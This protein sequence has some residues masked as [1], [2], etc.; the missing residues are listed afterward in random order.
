[1]PMSDGSFDYIVVEA[2]SAGCVLADRLSEGNQN[3]VLL[4]E[5]GD[6]DDKRE[7]RIPASFPD[8]YRTETDWEYYTT[9]QSE[10]RDR[11]LYWP[12]GRTLGG[13]SSINAMIYVRGHP[14]DYNRWA[15]SGNGEWAYEDVLPYF[16]R[17][18][19]FLGSGGDPEYHGTDGPMY[20]ADQRS[21]R[22]LSRMFVEAAREV[23]YEQNPDFNSPQQEGF[24]L[25]HVTQKEGRRHSVAD[26]FLKPALNRPNLT[27]ETGA[28][29]TRVL[30]KNDR[31]V[32]VNYEQDGRS[33]RA[34]ADEEVV[35][36]GGT[37]D[38]AQLLMLSGVGPADHLREYDIGVQQD[39]PGVGRNLQ[40]HLAVPAIYEATTTATLDDADSLTRLP[41]NLAKFFLLKRGPFTSN[42]GEAGGFVRT[43]E[44][45]PAPDLEF[46]FAPAYMMN[47]GLDNPEA[48]HGF[49]LG[50]I[51][52]Y[53]ES[54]GRIT[55]RSADPRE[56]PAIDPRYLTEPADLDTLVEGVRR[57][58]E[59]A[60]TLPLDNY[61]GEEVWPG[62]DVESDEAIADFIREK[63]HTIYHPVGTCKMGDGDMAVVDDRLTV[64]GVEGL[65]VVDAS[66][67]PTIISGHTN[68]PTVMIAEKAAEMIKDS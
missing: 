2:G 33:L 56:A 11:A 19:R 59:I 51:L 6:P 63:G 24:G 41:V 21:S 37:V 8:L 30:F 27:V 45:L 14:F 31:A 35:L 50:P 16:I 26:A 52:L 10:M 25:F 58:R 13:S 55:L 29:V 28:Y 32:G 4:L 67:M 54:R 7:I 5:A 44:N 36:S 18:E 17:S 20:V 34:D 62:E 66:I 42:L 49:S 65:R 39:L 22:D 53:P 68:A 3:E 9:P 46:I 15:D 40:D 48:G 38:S 23:G 12:R 60:R 1:M 61:R 47:H 64:H 43:D 57:I